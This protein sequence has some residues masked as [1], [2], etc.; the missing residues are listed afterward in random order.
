MTAHQGAALSAAPFLY[1][2]KPWDGPT[3]RRMHAPQPRAWLGYA[4]EF[5]GDRPTVRICAK[6]PDRPEA[7]AQAIAAQHDMT[8]TLCPACAVNTFNAILPTMNP[9][10]LD[11]IKAAAQLLANTIKT[12]VSIYWRR[13]EMDTRQWTLLPADE[14]PPEGF[15]IALTLSP[16]AP[17]KPNNPALGS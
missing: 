9:T 13:V 15:T 8:H 3:I 11:G 12:D 4:R 1:V 2:P 5:T 6:C 7:E 16:E 17:H 14:P 10:D